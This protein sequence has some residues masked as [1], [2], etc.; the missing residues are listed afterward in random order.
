MP[1]PVRFLFILLGPKKSGL[2]YHEVGR[3]IATLMSNRHF[4]NI[5]YKADDRKELL[6]AINEFLDDSIVLPPGKWDREHLLPFEELKEKNEYIRNRKNKAIEEKLKGHTLLSS[7]DEKKLLQAAEEAEDSGPPDDDDPLKRTGRFFGGMINDIKRRIPMYKSDIQDGL[8]TET[9]AATL[10]LYF[11]GLATAITFGGLIGDKTSSLVGIS[12]TLV[13]ACFVGMVFHAFSSQ[14]L[15]FVGTTGPLIL[16]DEALIKFCNSMGYSF[17]SVR[18]YVGFWLSIIALT[19]AAFEGSVYVRLFTRFTQEIFSALITLIYIVETALNVVYTFSRHPLHSEYVYKD[20][21][22]FTST[23]IAAIPIDDNSTFVE[24]TTIQA[25]I[26]EIVSN[27]TENSNFLIPW[28]KLGPLNQ[29]NT[30][31]F[32]MVLTLGTFTSA[33]SLRI[34]RNSKFL[35]RNA[36][37]ALGDFGVPISI[38][39]FVG[40]AYT[41]S[42]VFTDKLNVPDGISPSDPEARGWII[43]LSDPSIPK[44]M[45]IGALVPALLVYILIFMETQISELIVGKPERGLKKGNGLHW[46]IVLLCFCNTVCGYFGLPW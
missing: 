42:Q 45:P 13:S 7:E 36:R 29:P 37:R 6:S 8:N 15:V 31:L 21:E 18:V 11:A 33:Y 46:D 10:F 19:M 32:C 30:A 26:S 41:L 35:G 24:S 38:A 4:H 5:A 44:W 39:I 14:P 22:N 9:L 23:T 12:E 20:M 43:P 3:S 17:L 28:D 2:D 25:Q 40:I 27:I 16:F 1:I 34:F